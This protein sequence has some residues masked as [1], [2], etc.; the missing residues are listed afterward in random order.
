MCWISPGDL[1]RSPRLQPRIKNSM[2]KRCREVIR[3]DGAPINYWTL[4]SLW[5]LLQEKHGVTCNKWCNKFGNMRDSIVIRVEADTN[6]KSAR[7]FVHTLC[8]KMHDFTRTMS[9][10]GKHIQPFSQSMVYKRGQSGQHL[11]LFFSLQNF[12]KKVPGYWNFMEQKV[13]ELNLI[14]FLFT[15]GVNHIWKT[16]FREKILISA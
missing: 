15:K 1:A 5:C 11:E 7:F 16:E 13:L 3:G 4:H 9:S 14:P 8:H 6:H 10:I 12:V 2:L